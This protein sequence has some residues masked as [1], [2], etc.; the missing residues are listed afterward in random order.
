M[1]VDLVREK[2]KERIENVKERP[3]GSL[4]EIEREGGGLEQKEQV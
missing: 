2:V 3:R 1:W 4:E